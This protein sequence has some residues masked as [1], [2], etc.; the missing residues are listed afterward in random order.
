MVLNTQHGSHDIRHMH[1]D[2]PHSTERPPQYSR[3]PPH[4][5]HDIPHGTEHPLQYSRYPPTVLKISAHSTQDICP[6]YSRYPPTSIITS[7][8]VWNIPTVLKISPMVLNTLHSTH[9]VPYI[10]H[11]IP[12]WY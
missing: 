12:L 11:D 5:H 2:I 8:T 3:Y 1:H 4:M 6:Q 9:D 7:H 10:Y